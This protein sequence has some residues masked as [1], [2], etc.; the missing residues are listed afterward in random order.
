[1]RFANQ[2]GLDT[3]ICL[4]LS[5][6]SQ[7]THKFKPFVDCLVQ[8]QQLFD[9]R[10]H[11]TLLYVQF[12]YLNASYQ[13]NGPTA[14]G[15]EAVKIL[16]WL[17]TKK[18]VTEIIELRVPGSTPRAENEEVITK[19]LCGISVDILDWRVLD[20]SIDIISSSC[21]KDVQELHL[22]SSGNWGVLQQW[23]GVEGVT[24]LL[25]VRHQ[26]RFSL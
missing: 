4:D 3:K 18:G 7:R 23:S 5:I 14:I 19:A 1:M 13:S 9:V 17:R 10:F 8:E 24:L 11:P 12:P 21:A 2:R 6:F 16:Q 25:Q 22:Y 26:C 20:L 15:A